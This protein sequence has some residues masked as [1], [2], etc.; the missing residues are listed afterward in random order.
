MTILMYKNEAIKMAIFN[1]TSNLFF[2]IP[3]RYIRTLYLRLFIKEMGKDVYI[4]KHIDIRRPCNII[5]GD[6]VVINKKVLLDGRGGLTIGNNVDIAQESCIWTRHHDYNDD[7]HKGVSA[8]VSID[9]YAWICTRS[10]ILPGCYIGKGA[11]IAAGA[12][13]TKDVES[14]SVVGGI[15]A[16]LITIRKSKLLYILHHS[17][18]F[19]STD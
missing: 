13:V 12:V 14:M 7:Y 19:Y 15:P 3:I 6:H 17:P 4:A 8:P 11:I 16:K 9:D 5:V 2:S 10:I 1:L 18:R